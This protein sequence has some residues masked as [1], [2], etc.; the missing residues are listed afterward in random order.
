MMKNS[1][2]NYSFNPN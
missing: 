1:P 2:T